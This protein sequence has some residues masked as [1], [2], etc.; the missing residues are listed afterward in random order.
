MEKILEAKRVFEI[1]KE[2]VMRGLS[3]HSEFM[4]EGCEFGENSLL[5]VAKHIDQLVWE[6]RIPQLIDPALRLNP[7]KESFVYYQVPPKRL[8]DEEPTHVFTDAEGRLLYLFHDNLT[9]KAC[10][11][12]LTPQEAKLLEDLIVKAQ[13]KF[14]EV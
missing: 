6:R 5:L 11:F 12:Q 14:K 13:E 10:V 8:K 2:E 9:E 1:I 7:N 3:D 4:D